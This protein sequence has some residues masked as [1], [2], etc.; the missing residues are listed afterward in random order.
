MDNKKNMRLAVL[1]RRD[2]L[3]LRARKSKSAE[4]CYAVELCVSR[5]FENPCIGVFSAMQSEVDLSNLVASAYKQGWEV[6][7]PCMVRDNPADSKEPSRMV[8]YRVPAALYEKA[9]EALITH[10]LRCRCHDDLAFDGYESVVPHELDAVIVPLVA[11]DGNGNRLGYG[12]GN[13]DRLLPSL[14]KDALVVGVAFEEQR[15]EIVPCEPHDQPL[16][17]ILSA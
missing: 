4:L 16:P 8:F 6:C 1:A 7:F 3:P 13:Y 12:G 5:A 11:F 9:Y 15:V 10:P 17:Y 14:R 2:A